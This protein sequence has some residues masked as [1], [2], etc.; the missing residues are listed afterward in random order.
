MDEE[1]KF[2]V[3]TEPSRVEPPLRR[4]K[5]W[6]GLGRRKGGA[7]I[8]KRTADDWAR[9]TYPEGRIRPVE[10]RPR[11]PKFRKFQFELRERDGECLI[12]LL[13]RGMDFHGK[14]ETAPRG[15]EELH[16]LGNHQFEERGRWHWRPNTLGFY[17]ITNLSSDRRRKGLAAKLIENIA[18]WAT[19]RE[20]SYL[21]A[22]ALPSSRRA[23][24]EMISLPFHE[25]AGLLREDGLPHDPW[26]RT[27]VRSGFEIMDWCPTSHR[28]VT[29]GFGFRNLTS[30][31]FEPGEP[32]AA[33]QMDKRTG[34]LA[35]SWEY[36]TCF[37]EH[38]LYTWNWGCALMKRPLSGR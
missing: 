38:D 37:P 18:A 33:V 14:L 12:R 1:L 8:E 20:F 28:F 2:V 15:W 17:W 26:I 31:E 3:T 22:P 23:S 24:K 4:L 5:H 9:P 13:A 19:E 10:F 7:A 11:S 32:Q 36:V 30:Y 25:F 27:L 6:A 29:D 16:R 34:W 21:F 35:D